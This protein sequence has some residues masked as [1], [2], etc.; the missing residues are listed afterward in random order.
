MVKVPKRLV[1]A[2]LKVTAAPALA[3]VFT[4]VMVPKPPGS[5]SAKVAPV[6]GLGPAL[7]MTSV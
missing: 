4:E 2:L 3:T 6:A 5:V 7:A 1:F